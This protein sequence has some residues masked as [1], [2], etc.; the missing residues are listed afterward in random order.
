MFQRLLCWWVLQ[1]LRL[2][3]IQGTY[4]KNQLFP[5]FK[6]S[7]TYYSCKSVRPPSTF[8]FFSWTPSWPVLPRCSSTTTSRW[9]T[10]Q[11]W[12]TSLG[13]RGIGWRWETSSR[14]RYLH[15]HVCESWC[16]LKS[17]FEMY[18]YYWDTIDAFLLANVQNSYTKK[19]LQKT[20]TCPITRTLREILH[21]Q[22]NRIRS[23]KRI[24]SISKTF[25]ERCSNALR[26]QAPCYIYAVN[27][28]KRI[29][30]PPSILYPLQGYYCLD[31]LLTFY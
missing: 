21:L 16:F 26:H 30:S 25:D 14:R 13:R 24:S 20:Q 22:P 8:S 2:H 11:R 12:L 29:M 6:H 23:E 31:A 18:S 15:N 17:E 3:W 19:L 9:S 28:W 7:C 27:V 1:R 5:V 4:I 10:S